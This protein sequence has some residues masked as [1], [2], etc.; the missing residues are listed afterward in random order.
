MQINQRQK[1]LIQLLLSYSK[2]LHGSEISQR[3]NT[4]TRTL[5]QDIATIN[6]FFIKKIYRFTQ[7]Q[8][9]AIGSK[10]MIRQ[11]LLIILKNQRMI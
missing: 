4:T 9:R 3:I 10:K 8:A 5:R 2:P 11:R 6:T 1:S 7:T